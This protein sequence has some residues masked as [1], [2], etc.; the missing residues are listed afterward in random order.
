MCTLK[1]INAEM[2]RE[3]NYFLALTFTELLSKKKKQ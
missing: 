2:I 1:C 3:H